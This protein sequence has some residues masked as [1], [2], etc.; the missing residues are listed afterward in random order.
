M[1][2]NMSDM[3]SS[4]AANSELSPGL[5]TDV[6]KVGGDGDILT[7]TSGADQFRLLSAGATIRNFEVGTDV[8]EIVS[9]D[10]PLNFFSLVNPFQPGITDTDDGALISTPNGARTNPFV[11]VEG[12]TA[13]ELANSPESFAIRSQGNAV[14]DWN[15]ITFDSAREINVPPAASTRYFAMVHTAIADA[16]QGI[17]Q[18]EGRQTYLSTL[19]SELLESLEVTLPN[20]PPEG[21]SAEAAVA[22]AASKILTATFT[23]P[24]NPVSGATFFPLNNSDNP[25]PKGEYA[26]RVLS[27]ELRNSL[28]EIDASQEDIE[29][30]R[31]YGE[32]VA[33][34]IVALRR[35]DGAFRDEDGNRVVPADLATEY[36]DGIENNQN[37]NEVG[38]EDQQGEPENTG[39]ASQLVN[40]G[41][42]GRLFDGSNLIATGDP[43]ETT[44]RD[45]EPV[46]TSNVPTTPGAWR[47][48]ED[49]LRPDG[50]FAPLASIEI[51]DINLPWVLPTTTFFNDNVPPPPALDTDRYTY[52]VAEVMAEGSLL[53]IPGSGNVEVATTAGNQVVPNGTTTVDGMT[54]FVAADTDLGTAVNDTDTADETYGPGDQGNDF[55]L[56]GPDGLGTTSAERTVIAHVWAN[57][58][59]TYGPNYAWQPVAQQLAM[60]NDSSLQE[61]A[62]VFAALNVGLADGFINIWDTKWDEDAFWRPVSSVRNADQLESTA[63]FDDNNWT[64]REVTPQHPCHPSGTSM[65][66]GVAS[67][68]L[69]DF[70]GDNNTFTVSAAPHPNSARLLNA[71]TETTSDGLKAVDG[72]PLEEV[73][74]IYTSL[75]QAADESRTSRIYAGAHFR[76]ATENGV[77]M[78]EQVARYFLRHNPFMALG[79]TTGSATPDPGGTPSEP[80]DPVDP[81]PSPV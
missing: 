63:E 77:N 74:R 4:T 3:T 79:T 12:V 31:A 42:V 13:T 21:A 72:V 8:L 29:A 27:A 2:D 43:V 59:G 34:A 66:A 35:N 45:G 48:A 64:P 14:I 44:S 75:A 58:E 53:D 33:D 25:Q 22:S 32:Q 51:A 18:T 76:F 65:T 46:I 50:T 78:G 49:T 52:N 15:Q 1:A 6:L 19:D 80:P 37:L 28:S 7:G 24:D 60:N 41:T 39:D 5:N 56:N 47:R 57:A 23:D 55:G 69:T 70:Y 67:T 11:T 17:L 9:E 10:Q 81:V 20:E 62:N 38:G 73:S 16:V 30:G 26:S 36:L 68:I 40:D 71:L 54:S 61:T